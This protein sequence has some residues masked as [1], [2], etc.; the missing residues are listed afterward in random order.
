MQKH[1]DNDRDE[2]NIRLRGAIDV[3]MQDEVTRS[4]QINKM[5]IIQLQKAPLE[6][7]IQ[8]A[9]DKDEEYVEGQIMKQETIK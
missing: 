2:M 8:V 1:I 9:S 3:F 5:E 7:P 4:I 6:K